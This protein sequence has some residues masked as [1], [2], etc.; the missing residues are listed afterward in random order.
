M[1]QAKVLQE[2]KATGIAVHDI[3]KRR[4]WLGKSGES[5]HATC[6]VEQ[7]GDLNR[8]DSQA[9]MRRRR[10]QRGHQL[11]YTLRIFS[12]SHQ[13]FDVSFWRPQHVTVKADSR[14]PL[15][16]CLQPVDTASWLRHNRLRDGPPRIIVAERPP[17]EP[18]TK[19]Y[20][21]RQRVEQAA[22]GAMS[23]SDD[24]I[25][26]G[27]LPKSK[28]SALHIMQM[29]SKA[30]PPVNPV[31]DQNATDD[32][33]AASSRSPTPLLTSSFAL[34]AARGGTRSRSRTP[35]RTRSRSRSTRAGGPP[36]WSPPHDGPR[37]RSRSP[38]RP[39]PTMWVADEEWTAPRRSPSMSSSAW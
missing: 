25:L 11:L 8:G 5:L 37:T 36:P 18:F 6:E 33:A 39:P 31:A 29:T 3:E 38:R 4:I 17:G 16:G 22:A 28:A 32:G 19:A 26:P 12:Q 15:Q 9:S 24:W 34:A 1:T 10:A 30:G 35:R 2:A 23:S 27:T 20:D 14:F 13:D 7:A 21:Y